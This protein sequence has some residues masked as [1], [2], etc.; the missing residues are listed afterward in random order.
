MKLLFS[1][2][3]GDEHIEH[4]RK[5]LSA[6]RVMGLT[7]KPLKCQ[8]RRCYLGYLGH[9]VG[10]GKVAV[11]KHRVVALAEYRQPVRRKDLRC[12]SL[13]NSYHSLLSQCH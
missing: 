12:H 3:A 13:L 11:P 10:C 1:H 7:A 9:R 4:V 6:L 2:V 8:R 5:V